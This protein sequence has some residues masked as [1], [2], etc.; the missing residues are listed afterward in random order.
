M[1]A[2][3]SVMGSAQDG[4]ENPHGTDHEQNRVHADLAVLDPAP[5]PAGPPRREYAAVN[6]DPV[7][8][9]LVHHA[10]KHAVGEPDQRTHE[11]RVVDLVDEVLAVQDPSEAAFG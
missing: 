4:V 6:E 2:R 8:D 3:N 9:G 7:D 11:H 10:P 5:D 1:A